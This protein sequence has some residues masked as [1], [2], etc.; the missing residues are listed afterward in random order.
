M[1][2]EVWTNKRKARKMRSKLEKKK[3]TVSEVR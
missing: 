1:D 2:H 3:T